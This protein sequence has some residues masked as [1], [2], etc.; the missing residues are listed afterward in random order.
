M[1]LLYEKKKLMLYELKKTKSTE[2]TRTTLVI[3]Q[4]Q[5]NQ[6]VRKIEADARIKNW[7]FMSLEHILEV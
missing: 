2:Y 7:H 4:A 5:V 6:F 3:L 1:N